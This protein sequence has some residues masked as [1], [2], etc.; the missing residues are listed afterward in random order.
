MEHMSQTQKPN[1]HSLNKTEISEDRTTGITTK[2]V[3]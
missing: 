1:N 3:T 2:T